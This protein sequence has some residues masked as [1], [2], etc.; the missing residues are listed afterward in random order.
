MAGWLAQ[1]RPGVEAD[2]AGMQ[3]APGIETDLSFVAVDTGRDGAQGP[4]SQDGG[5]KRD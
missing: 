3:D 2:P 1:G 4:Q 5:K